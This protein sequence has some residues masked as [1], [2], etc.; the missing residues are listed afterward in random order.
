MQRSAAEVGFEV[1]IDNVENPRVEAEEH[2]YNAATPS[3]ST[4]G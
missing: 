2:Y 4:S 1:D 3:C